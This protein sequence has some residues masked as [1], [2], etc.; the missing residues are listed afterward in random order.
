VLA[1]CAAA[2]V[3]PE[4]S[5]YARRDYGINEGCASTVLFAVGDIN[6]DGI[7]DIVCSGGQFLLGRGDG[8]FTLSPEYNDLDGSGLALLDLNGDGNLDIISLNQDAFPQW[9]FKVA[10]GNGDAT[11]GTATFYPIAD[12]ESRSLAIGDFNG[13]GIPDAVTVADQGVWLMTGQGKGIFNAPVLAAASIGAYPNSKFEAADINKDGKLDLVVSTLGGFAVLFGNGDGTFQAP[14][15][16]SNPYGGPSITIADINSDGYLDII[17]SST[18]NDGVI[19]IFL[20]EAGG[21]FGKPYRFAIDNYEDVEV[22][23]VNGD[24]IPDLVSDAVSIAYG[25]GK[26][27]FSTPV[28]FAIPGGATSLVLAHLR[29]KKDLDIVTNDA[30]AVVSVLLNK[31]NGSYIEGSTTPLPSGLGCEVQADFNQDGISDFGFIQNGT[32]F[33]MEF[34]TGKVKAPF[35]TGPSTAIP[36]N[37]GYSTGCPAVGDLN[38]DGIPDVVIPEI[39]A[40]GTTTLLYP[41]FG[42]G[43]GNFTVGA[44]FTLSGANSDV[45][46]ADVNGDGKADLA[47]PALNE[48]WYGNGDGTFQAPVQL[49]TDLSGAI[50]EVVAADL[51]GDGITDLVVQMAEGGGT[52]AVES[53]GSGGETQTIVSDC[54]RSACFFTFYVGVGDLNGDGYP[55][56]VIGNDELGVMGLYLNNGSGGFTTAPEIRVPSLLAATFP[57]V[58]DVNGDGLNDLIVGDGTDI[59]IMANIG[60]LEYRQPVL[61]G[62]TTGGNYYFGNWHGQSATS[63]LPDIVMPTSDSVTM[64]INETK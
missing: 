54:S 5:F 22:G 15:D 38:G 48:L 47:T 13:D 62:Q 21:K 33:L 52:V 19:T 37:S 2:A 6:N 50:S 16:Y 43:N 45:V 55:D 63:G 26:G 28:S 57:Q 40:A 29:N 61:L 30:F 34:G 4:P 44:P 12:V 39:N 36:Q 56:L 46:L 60:N 59:C 51:N 23:D 20:G 41:F 35:S 42:T 14:V 10:F 18:Q 11:F 31:G 53:N 58:L 7:P 3:G 64:L 9:G 1:G 32:G 49:E 17:C 25:L 27:K 24:G 8:T